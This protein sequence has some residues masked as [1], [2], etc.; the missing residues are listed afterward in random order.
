MSLFATIL[1][2]LKSRDTNGEEISEQE[3]E[4]L[5]QA[6]GLDPS[7]PV[8]D[9]AEVQREATDPTGTTYDQQMWRKKIVRTVA[10]PAEISRDRFF[11]HLSEIWNESHALG[12]SPEG[13]YETAREAFRSAVRHVVAD[14]EI[15]QAEH[16]YL[17]ELKTVLG[18]PD[19]MASQLTAEIVKEAE[20][21]FAGKIKGA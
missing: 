16:I 7:D 1:G 12:L 14:K 6:W 18:L 19:E 11:E 20:A 4:A 13:I 17:E 2:L 15:T 10:D 21:I 3:R 5:R 8:L 9:S